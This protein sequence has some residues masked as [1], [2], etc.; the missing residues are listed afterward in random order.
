MRRPPSGGRLRPLI[1]NVRQSV[2]DGLAR[3]ERPFPLSTLG[4]RLR[5]AGV[6][7]KNDQLREV[8]D[9]L[10]RDGV[11]FEHPIARAGS[12]ASPCYWH[13]SAAEYVR[14]S[15]EEALP[16]QAE[17]SLPQ[18]R[19][20]VPKAYHD[21][22]EEQLGGLL[23]AG[24]LFEAPSRGKTRKVRTTPPRPSEGLTAAQVK[25][26][27]GALARVNEL[28]RP[29]LRLEELISFLDG[30]GPA[31]SVMRPPEAR[32]PTEDL[33]LRFYAED[34]PRREGLRSMPIP[35][36]WRRY[37]SHCAA[38]GGAPDREAFQALL[39]NLHSEGRVALAV[40]DAPISIPEGE[41][42]ALMT[43]Q[44]GRVLYYWTPVVERR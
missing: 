29:P 2:A 32:E 5:K 37:E 8:L 10:V 11:A 39:R 13:R 6:G 19:R 26:V 1:M 4:T 20:L 36:T 15:L 34:L 33:L 17:W 23:A 41:K 14:A 27:R 9:A 12:N 38:R 35:W 43:R 40:H 28:R 42:A 25:S 16:R 18:L 3:M 24:R 30:E 44:D 31:P 21:L 22:L 7:L